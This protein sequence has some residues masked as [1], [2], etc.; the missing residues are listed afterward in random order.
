MDSLLL[1]LEA[2]TVDL[3]RLLRS[4]LVNNNTIM[5]YF[6]SPFCG[7]TGMGG[8][9]LNA[10]IITRHGGH[11]VSSHYDYQLLHLRVL[12]LK[13]SQRRPLHLCFGSMR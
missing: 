11:Q 3:E 12:T 6:A 9:V 8:L 1:T 5:I 7:S 10:E 13:P 2:V 4:L